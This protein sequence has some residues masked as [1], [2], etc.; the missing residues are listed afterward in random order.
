MKKYLLPIVVVLSLILSFSLPV[1]AES[2]EGGIVGKLEALTKRVEAL[3]QV[4]KVMPSSI[5]QTDSC[6]S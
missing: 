2:E 4:I 5:H 6:S 3:E 1:K